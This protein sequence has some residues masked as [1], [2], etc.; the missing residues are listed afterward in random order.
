[1]Y[2]LTQAPDAAF[3][4]TMAS[5]LH[6]GPVTGI[7]CCVRKPLVA[8]CGVDNTVHVWN[9]KDCTVELVRNRVHGDTRKTQ[10]KGD[11]LAMRSTPCSHKRHS[12]SQTATL[13]TEPLCL[14]LHPSGLA[15]LVALGDR[16]CL[17]QLL[18]R[19]LRTAWEV[20]VRGCR[21]CCF[22]NGGHL[23]AAVNGQN[24]LLYDAHTAEHVGSLR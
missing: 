23:V 5:S 15:A 11:D 2:V 24:V 17:M 12:C 22:S 21:E 13:P 4:T 10:H 14:A 1:M 19:T 9:T 6:R 18:H 7:G 20:N 3:A 16:L 8:S